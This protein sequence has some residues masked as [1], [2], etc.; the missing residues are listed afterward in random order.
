MEEHPHNCAFWSTLLVEC[1]P[2]FCFPNHRRI[3]NGS[4][5]YTHVIPYSNF[6]WQIKEISS[7]LR[8][9]I[10]FR[11]PFSMEQNKPCVLMWTR[12]C[13]SYFEKKMCINPVQSGQWLFFLQRGKCTWQM[14]PGGSSKNPWPSL[15]IPPPTPRKKINLVGSAFCTFILYDWSDTDKTLPTRGLF[16][17]SLW[18]SKFNLLPGR[19]CPH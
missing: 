7:T 17:T 13:V 18:M 4:L 8:S 5:W 19:C 10:P 12:K 14:A 1:L 9:N 2:I 15:S 3:D 6:Q 11:P 16:K